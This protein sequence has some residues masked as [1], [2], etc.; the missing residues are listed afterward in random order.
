MD[1]W[2]PLGTANPCQV[3]LVGALAN[4]LTAPAE[5][6]E[7]YRAVT[8]RAARVLGVEA[9]YGIE[10]GRPGSFLVLD[11]ADSFDVVR[12]QVRPRYVVARGRVVA[13]GP[14]HATRLTWPG[15]APR[16]VDFRREGDA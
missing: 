11:A 1:P 10:V 9:E 3:A 12:R 6:A 8:D 2:Y 15:E 16:L 4:Q 7:C 14:E 5:I 13:E